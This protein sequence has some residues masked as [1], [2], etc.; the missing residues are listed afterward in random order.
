MSVKIALSLFVTFF[1]GIVVSPSYGG[2]IISCDSFEMCADGNLPLTNYLLELE[3]NPAVQVIRTVNVTSDVTPPVITLL[4]AN[5]VNMAVGSS[6]TDAG[7][8][9]TDNIDGDLTAN[10]ITI[11][12]VNTNLAGIYSV[13]Y[14]VSDAA[15][16]PAVQVIRTV[17]VITEVIFS[18]SF[19]Q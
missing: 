11:N 1:V 5:P 3:G 8:T 12:T 9:A 19:E 17:N 14:N 16:N 13:T 6:Y 4:G 15:G 10:I 18:D 2:D 7:A